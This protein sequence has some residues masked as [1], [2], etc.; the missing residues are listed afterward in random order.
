MDGFLAQY[1]QLHSCDDMLKVVLS[2]CAGVEATIAELQGTEQQALLCA[3]EAVLCTNLSAPVTRIS[4]EQPLNSG[5]GR[6]GLALQEGCAAGHTI[7]HRLH[8]ILVGIGVEP[9]ALP[10]GV[11][12][13]DVLP[14]APPLGGCCIAGA[15]LAIP[16]AVRVP[17]KAAVSTGSPIRLAAMQAQVRDTH[18]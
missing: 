15:G 9:T 4:L 7:L 6:A 5:L 13:P 1:M 11:S 14:A 8:G 12:M 3:Q 18:G 17:G 10:D 16:G 2:G